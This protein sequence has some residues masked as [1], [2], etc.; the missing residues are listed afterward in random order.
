MQL[1]SIIIILINYIYGLFTKI[2]IN[3]LKKT[4]NIIYYK[5]YEKFYFYNTFCPTEHK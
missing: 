4:K 3:Y 1:I 5:G 2:G